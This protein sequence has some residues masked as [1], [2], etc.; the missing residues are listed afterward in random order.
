[1]LTRSSS[2]LNYLWLLAYA[3]SAFL[4]F[5][6]L[7]AVAYITDL[8][9]LAPYSCLKWAAIFGSTGTYIPVNGVPRP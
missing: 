5:G 1:M 8:P 6:L 2:R 3:S 4:N 7:F 9:F